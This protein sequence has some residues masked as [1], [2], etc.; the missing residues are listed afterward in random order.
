MSI[1]FLLSS[2]I[3]SNSGKDNIFLCYGKVPVQQ[4][5]DFKYVILEEA[6]YTKEEVSEIKKKNDNV[7]CYISLGEVHQYV[8]FYKEAKKYT[9]QGKNTTW[10]S[11]YLDLEQKPLQHILLQNIQEK[12]RK[13][14][15]GLFLDNID[16][17][18]PYGKQKHL[19][20]KLVE[21]LATIKN[22]FPTIYL[23]QNAGLPLVEYTHPYVNSVAIESV[24]TNYDFQHKEYKFRKRRERKR[25]IKA[26][27][28]IEYEYKIPFL[29]I[30]YTNNKR[31]YRKIK[32][33]LKRHNWNLFI[34]QIDLQRKPTFN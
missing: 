1:T 17:Y 6:H 11:Y 12:L 19:Q 30:E 21:F 4:I 14:F 8:S 7:L 24:I 20:K 33:K 28:K 2:K 34:G 9:L 22:N 29:L 13:G 27:Q 23:M 31:K 16:N 10:N 5:V 32:R 26:L 18:G 3:F 15:D 25:I